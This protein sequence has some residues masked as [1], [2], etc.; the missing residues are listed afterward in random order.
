MSFPVSPTNLQSATVDGINYV[1]WSNSSAWFRQ[2]VN[3]NTLTVGNLNSANSVVASGTI[4]ASGGNIFVPPYAGT[5]GLTINKFGIWNEQDSQNQI[6]QNWTN[7]TG[8]TPGAGGGWWTAGG[9]LQIF[10]SAE[11]TFTLGRTL[12]SQN[13]PTG[14]TNASQQNITFSAAGQLTVA[15][16]QPS[17]STTTG[18]VVI[19]N[20]G[21]GVAG[22][23]YT[24][25]LVTTSG[26]YYANGVSLTASA[27]TTGKAIAMAMVFGG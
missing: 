7:G 16:T 2:T 20:G 24:A 25:N 15:N 8:A 23:I 5:G 11:L 17:T 6:F 4:F 22:N 21:L 27:A 19:T 13:Y 3:S 26:A 1:Y 10:S 18:A 9:G 12:R 14:G